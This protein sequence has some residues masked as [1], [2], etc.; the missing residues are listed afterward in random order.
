T[1]V[2]LI[3]TIHHLFHCQQEENHPQAAWLYALLKPACRPAATGRCP[4]RLGRPLERL[5]RC[6]WQDMTLYF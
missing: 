1:N 2:S 5:G 4:G 3:I 6:R